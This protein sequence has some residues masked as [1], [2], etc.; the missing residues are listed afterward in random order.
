MPKKSARKIDRQKT[1]DSQEMI[2]DIYKNA[3]EYMS[4]EIIKLGNTARI[5]FLEEWTAE[6][7]IPTIKSKYPERLSEVKEY[8]QNKIM[9]TKKRLNNKNNHL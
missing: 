5:K 1:P 7:L 3:I 6:H 2:I 9:V 4:Q 8:A